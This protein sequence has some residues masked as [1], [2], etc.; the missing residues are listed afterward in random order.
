MNVVGDIAGNYKTLLALLAKMPDH[1]VVSLG[2]VIDR[3]PRSKEC[4]Q[5]FIDNKQQVVLSNHDHM[6]F[7]L[8]KS[9][10]DPA[11]VPWY[12]QNRWHGLRNIWLDNGG[13]STFRSY[14]KNPPTGY[15]TSDRVRRYITRVVPEA[16]ISFIESFPEKIETDTHIFTHAPYSEHYHDML[17]GRKLTDSRW[18]T[19]DYE[20][21]LRAEMLG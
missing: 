16:H 15:M 2:D 17:Q 8:W 3:G 5:W 21:W 14:L 4:L 10:K 6:M 20:G 13:Y 9:M 18:A 7:D 12:S 1:E 19:M 11:Y